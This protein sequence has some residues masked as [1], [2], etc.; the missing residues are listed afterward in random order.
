MIFYSTPARKRWIC[1]LKIA[2][3]ALDKRTVDIHLV[4]QLSYF[5]KQAQMVVDSPV[6]SRDAKRS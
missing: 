5:A 3:N 2:H 1:A 4:A 6:R